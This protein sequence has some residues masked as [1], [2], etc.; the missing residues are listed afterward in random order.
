[1]EYYVLSITQAVANTPR[2]TLLAKGD[3]EATLTVDD[4]SRIKPDPEILTKTL[5]RLGGQIE[6]TLYVGDS[7]HDLEAAVNLGMPFL[8]VD[9]G[10]YVRGKARKKLRTS[11]E[12]H[13][14]PIVG[15]DELI[16]IRDITRWQT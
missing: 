16:G 15:L 2:T 3:C 14:F 6:R 10:L 4:V 1:M 9:S 12:R 7:S 13:G 5:E 8:L 11:A